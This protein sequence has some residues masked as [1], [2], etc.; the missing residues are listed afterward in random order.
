MGDV[1]HMH[2]NISKVD[3]FERR[4]EA[5]D[6]PVRQVSDKSDCVQHYCL[7]AIRHTVPTIGG[8]QGLEETISAF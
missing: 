4:L 7:L 1:S 2:N 5:L 6:E 3:L 8:A